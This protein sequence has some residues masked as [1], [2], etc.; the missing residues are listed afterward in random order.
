MQKMQPPVTLEIVIMSHERPEFLKR[1]LSAINKVDFG[2]LPKITISDNPS[3]LAKRVPSDL[4]VGY[5]YVLREG[6]GATAHLNKIIMETKLEWTLITHD[7]DEILPQLGELF[8]EYFTNPKVGMITGRSLILNSEGHQVVNKAYEQRLRK[9]KLN[10]DRT[11]PK[12]DLFWHLFDLGSL[13]PA[14]AMIVRREI[15]E[16]IQKINPDV[17]LASDYSFSLKVARKNQI[18][19]EGLAPV[20]RY[21]LH[22]NNSVFSDVA[23]KRLKSELTIAKLEELINFGVKL[24]LA[25]NL[26]LSIQVFQSTILLNAYKEYDKI[27]VLERYLKE[28]RKLNRRLLFNSTFVFKN[29]VFARIVR[30][31]MQRRLDK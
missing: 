19:F 6:L 28:Y 22:G 8:K 17:N 21:W 12:K 4:V 15:F 5:N 9:S 29:K 27:A 31:E 2:V 30:H 24:N 16:E 1:A 14:S 7:D 11:V 23:V 20:M 26:S 18:I 10:F 13:F 25:R 3:V